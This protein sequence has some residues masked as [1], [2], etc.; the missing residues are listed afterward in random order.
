L[1]ASD[2]A[3]APAAAT[4][5]AAPDWLV[6]PVSAVI[7]NFNGE[8]YLPDCIQ[9]LLELE[10]GVDEILV[11]DN[12]SDDASVALVRERFPAVR[13]IE[14]ATNGGPCVAR[15]AGMR[16]ARNRCVLAVDNDAVLLPDV[17]VKL[18]RA[19]ASR[20]G[21]VAAQPRSVF[22]NERDRVHYDAARFHYVGLLSLRNYYVPLAAAEGSGVVPTDGL[23][24][25]TVLLDRRAVLD[26]G[27]YDEDYFILFEDYDLALRLRIAGHRILSEEDAIVLHRGGTPGISFRKG[28]SYPAV[29]AYYHSRNRWILLAKNHGWRTLAVSLPGILLYELVWLAFSI[30]KGHFVVHLKG[31]WG[32]LRHLPNALRKRR[33]IQASR[34]MRDRELLVGGPLTLNPQLQASRPARLAVGVLDACLRGW[35]AVARRL[36]G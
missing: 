10:G 2:A 3:P 13:V 25:I 1:T 31:K 8:H 20:P 27:G 33:R 11:V 30:Q 12:A 9:A 4:G 14:L 22:Y 36:A 26:A 5:H 18:R 28:A 7:C 34:R 19:A 32:F 35:W 23:I 6:E 21:V 17:L 15:N 29:R 24:A 16:E